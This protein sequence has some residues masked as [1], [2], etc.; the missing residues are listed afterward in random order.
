MILARVRGALFHA[1]TTP[2][3][4]SLAPVRVSKD[5]ARRI[6][7]TLGSPLATAEDL[8][9]RQAARERLAAL[10]AGAAADAGPQTATAP[11]LVYFEKDRNTRE[12]GR[13]E[14]LLQAR[15]YSWK[16]LDVAGDEA[17]MDFVLL[18]AKCERDDLPVVFVAD[19][20]IGTYPA[21]VD[22]DVSGELARAIQGR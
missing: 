16:R 6:N 19:Q 21:L 12:L 9:K 5:I 22:A 4:D 7:V 10:R 13:V 20:A 1:I 14:E 15:G 2:A 8:A 17:T 11:V 18:K 3:G